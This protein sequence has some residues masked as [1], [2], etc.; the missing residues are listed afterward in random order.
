MR[1]LL[2]V[3]P[4]YG[5]R[6]IATVTKLNPGYVSKLLE[7]LDDEALVDRSKRGR[8]ERVDIKGLL[9]R[10]AESYDLFKT[11]TAFRFVAPKGAAQLLSQLSAAN[12]RYAVTGSFAAVKFAAV[13]AP[14]LLVAYSSDLESAGIESRLLPSDEGTNVIFLRP[15]D[16][17]VWDRTRIVNGIRYASVSQVAVDCLTGNGRM[18]AEGD[19]LMSWMLDNQ[20]DWRID[21]LNL[22]RQESDND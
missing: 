16:E 13:A 12:N 1:L 17:V 10:W 18:P 9:Q 20:A 14:A 6:E 21:S 7:T 2:D 5:V 15:Y 11:N 22:L 4:P 3:T 19:A 8:V